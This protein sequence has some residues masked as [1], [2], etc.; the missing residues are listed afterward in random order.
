MEISTSCSIG[1]AVVAV[2]SLS[3]SLFLLVSGG[4]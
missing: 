3:L 4:E 2:V 1:T